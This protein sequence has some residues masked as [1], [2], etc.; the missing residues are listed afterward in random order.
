MRRA[1]K[2]VQVTQTGK[3]RRSSMFL[4][5]TDSLLEKERWLLVTSAPEIPWMNEPE[6]Q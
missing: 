3:P 5:G 4:G 2:S 6:S 1:M